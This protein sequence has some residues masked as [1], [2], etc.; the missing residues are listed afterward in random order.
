MEEM[1]AAVRML[2][3]VGKQQMGKLSFVALYSAIYNSVLR[4]GLE[5]TL[6]AIGDEVDVRPP[7]T[8]MSFAEWESAFQIVAGYA[9]VAAKRKRG[10]GELMTGFLAKLRAAFPESAEVRC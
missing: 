9:Y 4:V 3:D 7:L 10:R 8:D 6:G 1:I 5:E 2:L